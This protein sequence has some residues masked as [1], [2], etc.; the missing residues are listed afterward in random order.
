V[1]WKKSGFTSFLAY[2]GENLAREWGV[3]SKNSSDY[4]PVHAGNKEILELKVEIS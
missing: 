2:W 3:G 1:K 4:A